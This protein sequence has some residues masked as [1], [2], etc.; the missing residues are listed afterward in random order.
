MI[1]LA[2]HQAW[3]A[4]LWVVTLLVGWRPLMDTFALSL[5]D[6]EYTY[7]LLILPV[8]AALVFMDWPSLRMKIAL[9]LPEGLVF[10]ETAAVIGGSALVWAGSLSPDVQ[11]SIRMTALVF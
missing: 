6:D 4:L 8:S 3:L 5:R 11:L 10:L 1:K 9:G 7:I 2:K